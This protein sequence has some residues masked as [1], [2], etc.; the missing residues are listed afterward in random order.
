MSIVTSTVLKEIGKAFSLKTANDLEMFDDLWEVYQIG[1][2]YRRDN[3]ERLAAAV[4]EA[5]TGLTDIVAGRKTS[6]SHGLE[7]VERTRAT[8]LV[9][10]SDHHMTHSGHRHNYF[11]TFNA[12]LY[13]DVL[14]RYA[15]DGVTLVENGDVE[16]LLIFEPTI[17]EAEKRRKLVRRPTLGLD[18]IGTID[19]SELDGIR[20]EKRRQDLERMITDNRLYYDSVRAFG[21]ERYIKLSGNHDRY[22]S[23]LLEGM[24]ESVYWTGVVKDVL[25]VDRPVSGSR[26]RYLPEFVVTHGHQFDH[27]CVPPHAN[28]VGESISECISW[29]FQG[30]D[31]TWRISDTR[32]WTKTG[33]KTF[34]NILSSVAAKPITTG[35]PDL[36]LFLEILMSHEIAW[37]YFEND[38]PYMAFVRE[39]CTGDEFFKY[40]HMD[41][42]KLANALLPKWAA[43]ERFPTLICGHTH[44]VRDRSTF[45][46]DAAAG[47]KLAGKAVP[48]TLMPPGTDNPDLYTRYL[49]TG[50]AG[51][52][53]NLIWGV[54][55]DGS[56]A[57]VV[58]WT[59]TGTSGTIR[60]KKTAWRSDDRGLLVGTD[61]PI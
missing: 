23:S 25:L 4:E 36:E 40:R 1:N 12:A 18:D 20:V 14:K 34:S 7:R 52:F 41:E 44:E 38:D 61:V 35:H 51:R 57:S 24:I 11:N 55:I 15:D 59:N 45:N 8:R 10:F 26:T 16:E 3:E 32:N 13:R 42:D 22:A 60:P 37:E 58:S 49:N 5:Y 9:I 30:P 43:L 50:S 29:A 46:N 21:R 48:A 39:V 27:A 54:E 17:A 28:K 19:W 53:E 2:K 6:A 31:R 33:Q 47:F 56:D